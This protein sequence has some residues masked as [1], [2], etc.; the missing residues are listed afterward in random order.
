MAGSAADKAGLRL[1]DIVVS[2]DEEKID[3]D[4]PLSELIA[5]HK[6]GNEVK[7]KILRNGEEAELT[8]V[9]E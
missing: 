5:K 9:L 6:P 4:N 8:A 7:L 1:G 2:V 3:L